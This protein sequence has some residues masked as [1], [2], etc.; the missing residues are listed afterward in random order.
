MSF[1]STCLTMFIYLIYLFQTYADEW[2]KDSE[3]LA[4]AHDHIASS[5]ANSKCSSLT[6]LF[7]PLL[8]QIPGTDVT[9]FLWNNILFILNF[10]C[11]LIVFTLL[12]KEAWDSLLYLLF[13]LNIASWSQQRAMKV[14]LSTQHTFTLEHFKPERYYNITYLPFCSEIRNSLAALEKSF[15]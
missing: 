14:S 8:E 2:S 1:F 7:L 10:I 9:V 5:V 15:H 3:S 13:L 11:F 4:L 12:G 6:W